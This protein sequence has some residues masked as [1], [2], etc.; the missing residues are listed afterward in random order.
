MSRIKTSYQPNEA[1]PK[2]L[3]TDHDWFRAHE[4]E[5]L[6]QYGDCWLV[7]YHEEILGVGQ[8][9]DEAKQNAEAHLPD[10]ITQ[11]TPIIEPLYERHAFSRFLLPR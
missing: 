3:F 11:V 7:I 2:N 5:L 1:T 10:D 8:T 9:Y 4:Q 6:A